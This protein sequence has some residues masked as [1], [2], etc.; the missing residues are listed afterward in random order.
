MNQL[1]LLVKKYN[2]IYKGDVIFDKKD[3][4]FSLVRLMMGLLDVHNTDEAVLVMNSYCLNIP[5]GEGKSILTLT[6]LMYNH[7]ELFNL[8]NTLYE[9]DVN[10][11][12]VYSAIKYKADKVIDGIVE[13]YNSFNINFSADNYSC[14]QRAILECD[15]MEFFTVF[16]S[17]M[18]LFLARAKSL[19]FSKSRMI[20]NCF[21]KDAIVERKWYFLSFIISFYGEIC[22]REKDGKQI[23]KDDFNKCLQSDLLYTLD[24]QEEVNKVIE[25]IKKVYVLNLYL[26]EE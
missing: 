25:E 12:L 18:K 17:V 6:A 21:M 20:Y 5:E 16:T 15:E 19:E 2:K 8:L 3:N 23:M 13:H 26:N 22:M 10:N 14:I 4:Y 11:S 1:D 24:S 7:Y 9:V